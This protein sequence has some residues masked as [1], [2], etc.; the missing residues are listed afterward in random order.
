MVPAHARPTDTK[1]SHR[2]ARLAWVTFWVTQKSHRV[3]TLIAEEF[4]VEVRSLSGTIQNSLFRSITYVA[5]FL[6]PKDPKRDSHYRGFA[7][8]VCKPLRCQPNPNSVLLSELERCVSSVGNF[9]A[10]PP[11]INPASGLI[12]PDPTIDRAR[13]GGALCRRVSIAPDEKCI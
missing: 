2:S 10:S 8:S 5:L 7:R 9:P 3:K 13:A 11:T 6:G 4:T 1:R 12:A